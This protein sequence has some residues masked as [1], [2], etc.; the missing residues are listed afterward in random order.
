M[1]SHCQ[2]T[3]LELWAEGWLG[4]LKAAWS[5]FL[6]APT[7]TLTG[8]KATLLDSHLWSPISWLPE[9]ESGVHASTPSRYPENEDTSAV[10]QKKKKSWFQ[11][12][13][14]KGSGITSFLE[15]MSICCIPWDSA[16][17]GYR[18]LWLPIS[19]LGHYHVTC[20][21]TSSGV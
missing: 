12:D 14:S 7:P 17:T 15:R 4:C 2:R 9:A 19:I 8:R 18:E 11:G 5:H 6:P 13:V 1:A 10:S 16:A 21:A 20:Y 3:C